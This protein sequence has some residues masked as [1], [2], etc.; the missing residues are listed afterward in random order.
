MDRR[1]AWVVDCLDRE[2]RGR[3]RVEELAER[4]GIGVSRL[5]HLF[6]LEAKISIREYVRERRLREAASLLSTTEER[7]SAI[8]YTCGY[9]DVS[10]FNHAFKRCFGMSPR[11]YRARTHVRSPFTVPAR[12][13]G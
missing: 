7:I 4:V 8:S 5:E 9:A 10:N 2:W 12:R 13:E 1:V 6:K 3:V 11:D